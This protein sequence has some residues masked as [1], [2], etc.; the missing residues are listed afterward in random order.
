MR[1]TAALHSVQ[2]PDGEEEKP[3]GGMADFWKIYGDFTPNK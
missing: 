3:D 2:V 1:N